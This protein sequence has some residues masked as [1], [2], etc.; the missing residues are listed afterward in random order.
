MLE[1]DADAVRL[2]A[3][4]HDIGKV[5]HPEELSEPGHAHEK[6]GQQ[7]LLQ[8]GWPEAAARFAMTH[9]DW[10]APDSQLEDL[11]V[12]LADKIWKGKRDGDLEQALT[13]LI[14]KCSGEQLWDVW[15][16]LDD[17]LSAIAEGSDE[18]LVWQAEYDV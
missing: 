10:N 13:Q 4:I 7:L 15:L 11:L 17:I 5:I 9:A 2:G 16:R 14:H 1:Y 3:A 8:K 6:A 12:A 18:C